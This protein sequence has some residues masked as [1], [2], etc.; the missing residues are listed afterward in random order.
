MNRLICLVPIVLLGSCAPIQHTAEINQPTNVTSIAGPGDLLAR[1]DKKRNLVNAFGGADVFGRK[2][3]EGFSELRFGGVE[4]DGTI[5]FFRRETAIISNETTMSR[6]PLST[7]YSS[8]SGSVS[9]QG[10][11]GTFTGTET[12]TTLHPLSDYHVVIPSDALA[13][14][15][16]KGTGVVPFEGYLIDIQVVSQSSITYRVEKP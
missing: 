1:V 12:T 14:R 13:I 15:L 9:V 4:S 8:A 6:T 10:N 7:S 16:P 11:R 3:D 2:T 5:V